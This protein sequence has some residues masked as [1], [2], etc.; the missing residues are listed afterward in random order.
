MPPF[1][2]SGMA[3]ARTESPSDFLSQTPEERWEGVAVLE[4]VSPVL[5]AEALRVLAAMGHGDDL[6]L[7]DRN[8]PAA[9]VASRTVIGR[10]VQPDGMQSPG[11]NPFF[12]S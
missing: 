6:T 11:L 8:F 12:A 5:G 3:L 2:R 10:L 9:E 7:L 1:N 4:G